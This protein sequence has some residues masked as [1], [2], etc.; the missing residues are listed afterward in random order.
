MNL[1]TMP[2]E[3]AAH[4]LRLRGFVLDLLAGEL[5]TASGELA[6]LRKQALD[7]LLVLG[8]RAGQVVAKDELMGLV[9]PQVVVGEGSLTQAVADIRR[10]LGDGEHRI[11]RNVARRGY[12][13]VPDDAPEP[14]PAARQPAAVLAAAPAPDLAPPGSNAAPPSP[15]ATPAAAPPRRRSWA[16][17]LGLTAVLALLGA[18][19]WFATRDEAPAWQTPAAAARP[20]LPEQVPALSIAVMPL[21]VEGD[22]TDADWLADALHGDLITE[23]ARTRGSLVIGRDT[24]V[25]YKARPVDPREVARE[26]GVRHVVR[27]SLRR[28]GEQ[29]RLNLALV[30]GETGVQRWADTFVAERAALPRTLNDFAV[31]VERALTVEVF[32]VSTARR[33]ALSP[34][35]ASADDLAMRAIA[36]W[37]R[38]FNRENVTEGLALAERAVLLDPDSLRGWHGVAYLTLHSALN[39]WTTDRGAALQRIEAAAA[40]L[41]RIDREH[42]TSYN[43]K[44]I[45]LFWKADVEAMLRHTRTWVA[46]HPNYPQAHGAL[47]AALIFNGHFDDAVHAFERALRLSPRDAFRA[48]W[49]YRLSMAHFSAGRYE[50]AR[51]WAQTAATTNPALRWPPIHAAALVRLGRTE[52][53]QQAMAEFLA[54]HR[55]I[56]A[57]HLNARFPGQVPAMVAARDRLM[58]ALVE[59]GMR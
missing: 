26:L 38:G 6:G 29:I 47:G 8:R 3:Q 57:A 31:Q 21:T 59:A 49:Q 53:A 2:T 32:R 30:D 52:A 7:V 42:Y 24:M 11:V 36:L 55:A 34:D 16:A 33:A 54:R 1:R 27:G 58:A 15:P 12:M 44:T 43:A 41:E 20:P 46:H 37:H 13:L 48:E 4:R 10:V 22:P 14:Q 39:G 23:I 40:Q 5:F 45:I 51:D 18:A 35:Q 25:S 28:E 19:A 50:L 17:T 9:W 56:D